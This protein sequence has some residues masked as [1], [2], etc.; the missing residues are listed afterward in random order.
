MLK[1]K[2]KIF[3]SIF[4]LAFISTGRNTIF[5]A[6]VHSFIDTDETSLFLSFV[7]EIKVQDKLIKKFV[8]EDDYDK[9]EKHL[10]RISQ[11]YTDEIR[12]E[13]SER[14]ERI[15]NEITDTISVIGHQIIQKT[16]KEEIMNSIDYLDGILDESVSVRLEVCFS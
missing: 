16:A 3:P 14:N 8:S 4:T 6:F 5:N 10:S 9:A 2:S 11:L 13:L 7:D 1:L 12:D 15:T